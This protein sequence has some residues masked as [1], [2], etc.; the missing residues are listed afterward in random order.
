MLYQIQKQDISKAADTLAESFL[1]YPVFKFVLPDK[2]YRKDKINYLFQFLIKLGL[3][4]GEVIAS[5]RNIEGVSIWINST[6]TS[7]SL[8]TVIKAGLIQLGYNI[9]FESFKRFTAI[10]SFKQNQR[11]NIMQG[12]YCLLDVIGVKPRF[13]R[14]GF[15]KTIIESKLTSLDRTK[16][17]CYLETSQ[18]SNI[19]YYEKYS[20]KLIQHYKY[21][22]TNIFCLL[23][24]VM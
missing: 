12:S 19:K 5:S 21:F 16:Q 6:K 13:Q 17:P 3:L 4:N 1:D 24:E 9:G 23:R 11:T 10:G 22:D 18:E 8:L 15:A 20:F 7:T 14:Q 2:N